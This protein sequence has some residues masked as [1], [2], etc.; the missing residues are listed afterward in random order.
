MNNSLATKGCMRCMTATYSNL[1]D[2]LE[3]AA[4]LINGYVI[5]TYPSSVATCKTNKITG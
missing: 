4:H 1:S 3:I 5:D 2:P